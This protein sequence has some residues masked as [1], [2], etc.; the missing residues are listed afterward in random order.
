MRNSKYVVYIA[1]KIP[2]S[3]L[4]QY[5]AWFLSAGLLVCSLSGCSPAENTIDTTNDEILG[6]TQNEAPSLF[7]DKSY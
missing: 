2:S 1:R 6:L 4:F 5:G 3:A 7:N